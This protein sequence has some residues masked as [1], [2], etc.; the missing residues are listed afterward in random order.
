MRYFTWKIDWSSGV[1]T[2]PT[3]TINTE[4]VRIE[5]AFATGPI[6]DA[7]TLVYCYLLQGEIDTSQL[8]QWSVTETTV[9][10]MLSAAQIIEPL[11]VLTNGLISFPRR[12]NLI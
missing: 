6:D 2:D 9:E 10:A 11:A 4:V 12:D 5:P 8:A 7:S 3:S 1:G